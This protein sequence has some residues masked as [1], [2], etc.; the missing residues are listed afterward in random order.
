[1]EFNWTNTFPLTGDDACF[2]SVI[3]VKSMV[4]ALMK[5]DEPRI[6]AEPLKIVERL[7]KA[8]AETICVTVY[9]LM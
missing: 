3:A 9:T 7:S 2:W 6:Y 4:K 8:F 1:M 5:L